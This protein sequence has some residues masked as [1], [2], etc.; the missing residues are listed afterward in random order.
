MGKNFSKGHECCGT[1]SCTSS[2]K[3]VVLTFPQRALTRLCFH[4]EFEFHC[5]IGIPTLGIFSFLT[6]AF[7]MSMKRDTVVVLI[8]IY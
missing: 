3:E 6:F 4:P 5:A 1:G 8:G 2:S 7:L